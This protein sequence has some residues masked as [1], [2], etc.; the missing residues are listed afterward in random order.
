MDG[1]HGQVLS[2]LVWAE[3]ADWVVGFDVGAARAAAGAKAMAKARMIEMARWKFSACA[4]R[5]ACLV[6]RNPLSR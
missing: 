3:W 2:V 5:S 4:L 1:A 6:T